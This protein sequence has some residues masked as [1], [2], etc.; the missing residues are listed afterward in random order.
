MSLLYAIVFTGLVFS[1]G[2]GEWAVPVGQAKTHQ[3]PLV[4]TVD[5]TEKFDKTYPLDPDGRVSI[6]N[7]NGSIIVDAWDRNEV[8]VTYTK[9]AAL[10]EHLADVQVGIRS[11]ADRIDIETNYAGWK[12][13]DAKSARAGQVTVDYHLTV[14]RTAFLNEIETVN[15]SVTVSSFTNF[16]RASAVNGSVKAANLRG[17][18]NLSTVNGEV[19]ADFDR[20]ETG[21]KIVLSTVNGRVN[22]SI[23]SDSNATI[24]ADSLNG[25]I[26]N[27][28]GLPVRKGRYVGRDLYGVIGSGGVRIKLDSVNGPLTISR[29]NDGRPVSPATDLLPKKEKD[30]ANWERNIELEMRMEMDVKSSTLSADRV[31]AEAV[32]DSQKETAKAAKAVTRELAKI[33]PRMPGITAGSIAA[34]ADA[35]TSAAAVIKSRELQQRIN[36]T[37]ARQNEIRARRRSDGFYSYSLP[38]AKVRKQT[39][40]VKGVPN[41]TVDA[42][43]CAVRV[44]GWDRSEVQ[45]RA[46]RYSDRRSARP[47]DIVDS[48]T[49]SAV[50]IK[51]QNASVDPRAGEFSDRSRLAIIDVYVPM[52]T[53]LTIRTNGEIRVD[54]VSGRLDLSGSD[55]PINVRDSNG[56]LNVLNADGR[57]RVIGF[58]GGVSAQTD[59]GQIELEGHFTQLSA[60]GGE[61]S[62]V[63]TLPETTSADIETNFAQLEGDGIVMTLVSSGTGTS[64]YRIGS[65]RTKYLVRTGGEVKIRG[66]RTITQDN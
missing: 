37:I 13:R 33:D 47:I 30:G 27:D 22:L 12:A 17:A 31:V 18:A 58:N 50:N 19:A 32:K 55:E 40:P 26:S 14:P 57:I 21:S 44:R 15:G 63:L 10:K 51:V 36:K 39:Y 45:Y 59:D 60:S 62:V 16:T 3:M 56:S 20:L 42:E 48:R 28:F 53:D 52:G 9:T 65:G 54:G 25:S 34:A 49:D 24:N 64:I 35:V 11:Q 4:V 46:S 7:D 41:V 6:S 1:S 43:G 5:E 8:R 29:K 61:G 2:P 66:A 38:V 23:P